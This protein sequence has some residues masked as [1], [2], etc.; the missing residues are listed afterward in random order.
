VTKKNTFKKEKHKKQ[1]KNNRSGERRLTHGLV[2]S[3]TFVAFNS[4]PHAITSRRAFGNTKVI[5][6][7]L[8]H[9]LNRWRGGQRNWN[10]L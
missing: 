10:A 7:K 6:W 1:I 5:K 4:A 3:K 8:L 9:P 2:V